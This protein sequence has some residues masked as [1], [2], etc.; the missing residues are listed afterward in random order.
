MMVTGQE[1]IYPIPPQQVRKLGI[2]EDFSLP[3]LGKRPD[4]GA[5]R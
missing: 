4:R 1:D 5:T 2:A 3:A